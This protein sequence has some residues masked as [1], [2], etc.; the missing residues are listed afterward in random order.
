MKS[1]RNH[2]PILDIGGGEDEDR[3]L[4]E[5]LS[6]WREVEMRRRRISQTRLKGKMT[7]HYS[8]LKHAK[9]R[10]AKKCLDWTVM[11]SQLSWTTLESRSDGKNR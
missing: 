9:W 3:V 11:M 4:A 5:A 2:L 8:D 10:L 1:G 7:E 6:D